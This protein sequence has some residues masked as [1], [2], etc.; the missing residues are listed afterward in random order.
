MGRCPGANF[1][2]HGGPL[3]GRGRLVPLLAL[4]GLLAAIAPGGAHARAHVAPAT[5]ALGSI[6]VI[7][8]AAPGQLLFAVNASPPR[9]QGDLLRQPAPSLGQPLSPLAVRPRRSPGCGGDGGRSPPSRRARRPGGRQRRPIPAH[10]ALLVNGPNSHPLAD[11]GLPGQL[12]GRDPSSAGPDDRPAAGNER[13][14]RLG[15]GI[16]GHAGGSARA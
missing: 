3:A 4:C 15:L 1:L 16:R 6:A 11:R 7:R 10:T 2:L 12:D 9:P 8:P 5:E 13:R 14:G